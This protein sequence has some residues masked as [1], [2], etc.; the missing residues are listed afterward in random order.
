MTTHDFANNERVNT[1]FA[2]VDLYEK[3]RRIGELEDEKQ[4]IQAEIDGLMDTLKSSMQHVDPTSLL[5]R[6]LAAALG[7]KDE[8]P[9]PARV[10]ESRR[11]ARRTARKKATASK[12]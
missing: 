9:V 8:K 3:L 5:Y 2:Q 7:V 1:D 4:R 11:V 12:S 10:A 6:V